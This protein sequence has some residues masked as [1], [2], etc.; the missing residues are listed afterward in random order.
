MPAELR[1]DAELLRRAR[2]LISSSLAAVP[3]TLGFAMTRWRIRKLSCAA[4][5]SEE[6]LDLEGDVHLQ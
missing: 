6:T 4:A 5:H 2:L 3:I 1:R